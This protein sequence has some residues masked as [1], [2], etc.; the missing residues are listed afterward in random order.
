MRRT[1]LSSLVLSTLILG[2][3]G[4]G[5]EEKETNEP[6]S[7]EE[8]E[9]GTEPEG[10][11]AGECSDEVDND[12]DGDYDCND[13][14]CAGSLDCL[15][16][17]CDDGAD[18][19]LDG[20]FDCD[21]SD[22]ED[23][24]E[25]ATEDDCTD[26]ADNDADGLFDCDDPDC[27]EDIACVDDF[28]GDEPGEC[29]DG[30]D[31]DSNGLVDCDDPNCYGS[32][33]CENSQIETNLDLGGGQSIAMVL[34]PSGSDPLG[35]YTITSAFYM[36]KT[37]V[38]QGMFTTLMGYNQSV[39]YGVGND[40]PAHTIN[41]HMSAY[42]A[43][44]VTQRHNTVNSTSLQECYT[45]SDFRSTSVTCSEAINPY[46]CTGYVL[47]TEGEW[48]YA[49]RS[50][51]GSE[52]WTPDGSGY[53]SANDCGNEVDDTT[54]T[55]QDGVTNPALS[56]YAWFCGNRYDSDYYDGTKPVGLKLPNGFGL[57]DM[58][59]NV[60]EWTTDWYGCSFPT[61]TDPYCSTVSSLRV[62]RGG[63]WINDPRSARASDRVPNSPTNA[64]KGIGFR[65][66]L[67]P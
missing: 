56:D 48:E 13:S 43:N 7:E 46:Q 15:E 16:S 52:F 59:G 26:G 32:S 42:F 60:F 57:Y 18:N 49:A 53:F 66:G 50:G 6:S 36:M 31:N 10:A 37:E 40:Y 24:P 23:A 17:D 61:S 8:N 34:I 21:D 1:I 14:D 63:N 4:C 47:P 28:E 11:N 2:F 51:T 58:H 9:T 27:L 33:D 29:T 38:T 44:K 39:S 12:F 67:H 22:C 30:V 55:I 65:L 62:V 3:I 41:W 54:V 64:G 35:T 5:E 20:D 19:D 25:C 45:C